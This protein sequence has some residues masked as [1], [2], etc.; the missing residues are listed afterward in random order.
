MLP[1]VVAVVSLGLFSAAAAVLN[2]SNNTQFLDHDKSS[3]IS[4]L[5]KGK[6]RDLQKSFGAIKV[7]SV[8]C[9]RQLFSRI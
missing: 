5:I 9:A 6:S 8:I 2:I 7:W 4:Q 1:K 3:S